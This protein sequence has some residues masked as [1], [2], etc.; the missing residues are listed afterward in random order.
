MEDSPRVKQ[1]HR[2]QRILSV[3]A[4]LLDA[5]VLVV[6]LAS[7]WSI[8]MRAAAERLTLHPAPAL[9]VYLLFFGAITKVVGLPLDYIRGFRLE[10]RY[11]LSNLRLAGWVKDQ[12]K[13]L[14]VGGLLAAVGLECLYG[15][16]RRWPEHWWIISA[17]LFVAFFVLLA[18]LA[19]V[20]I[21]PIFF[22][23]KPLANPALTERLLELSRRAGTRVRGVF[24]WKLSEKS[25]KANAALVGLGNTRRII[26]ADTLLDRFSDDEVEAVLAHELGHHVH[27]HMA[28]N[29][30]VQA[31]A[32]YFGFFVVDRILARFS[33]ACGF[34]GLADFANLPLLLLVG[35][36]LSLL[37]LP[38]VNGFSRR[39]ER[40]AD[41]YA[42]RSIRD[43]TTFISSMEKLAD[44]NLAETQ[45]PAWIEFIFHSHPSLEKRIAFAREF[46]EQAGC[47]PATAPDS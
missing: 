21:F 40:Q 16:M 6:L 11:G 9:L 18:N 13:G 17:T 5:L 45:P 14:A 25:K 31:V 34:R 38:A 27:H 10:H 22:K 37:L 36:A 2:A 4:F 3:A 28:M 15:T 1:Y 43:R 19:P 41:A 42:L 8:S 26:L 46:S 23:F 30:A 44:L 20:L 32:T 47:D 12:L 33:S 39:M 24:E 7:G 35:T 29:L